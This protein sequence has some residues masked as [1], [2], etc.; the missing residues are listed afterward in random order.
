[1]PTEI[2][3]KFLVDDPAG[4]PRADGP[5]MLL[6]QGYL[7]EDG[8]VQVRVRD[9]G[10]ATTMTAKVGRGVSRHEVEV[11]IGRADFDALWVAT[12]GRRVHK[13]RH[14]IPLGA[15]ADTDAAAPVA[16][17]LVAELD[18][19]GDDLAGLWLVEV[20]FPTLDAAEAFTPPAWFGREVTG[21]AAW[22][23][24][25]LARHGRPDRSTG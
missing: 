22:S 1:M 8:D 9:A 18:E 19:Y 24:A 11:T 3:R 13:T 16:D 15:A 7:A 25:A 21:D 4:V 23:N 17:R 5:G 20:E 2:E 6:R 12:A 14:R 10:G